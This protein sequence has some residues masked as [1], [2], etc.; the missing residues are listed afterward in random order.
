MDYIYLLL[1][2]V[3]VSVGFA[4][5]S[6]TSQ[7]GQRLDVAVLKDVATPFSITLSVV[8]LMDGSA[9]AEDYAIAMPLEVVFPSNSTMLLIP[10]ALSSDEEEED[11]EKFSLSLFLPGGQKSVVLGPQS[12]T[13]VSIEDVEFESEPQVQHVYIIM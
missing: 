10:M 9:G 4:S 2:P 12:I 3:D 5:T 8:I 11:T 7:E 13:E 6:Y 1:F